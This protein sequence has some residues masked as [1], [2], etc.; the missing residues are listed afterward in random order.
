M[1]LIPGLVTLLLVL[2]FSSGASAHAS[3]VSMEPGNGSVLM[4][5]PKTVQLH[6]N[7]PVTSVVIRLIDAEGSTRDDTTRAPPAKQSSSR[8][9]KICRAAP[10]SSAT[11]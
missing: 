5:A 3:L 4:Q 11:A 8:C 7:E 9:R 10:R 1:R 2:C 6:F